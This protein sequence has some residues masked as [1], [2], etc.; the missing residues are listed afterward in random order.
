M[1]AFVFLPVI[2]WNSL[3][4][5]LVPLTNTVL[6]LGATMLL[7]WRWVKISI[8]FHLEAFL[9]ITFIILIVDRIYYYHYWYWYHILNFNSDCYYYYFII[10]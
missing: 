8:Y 3:C 10:N 5:V 6:L 9:L 7:T 4:F 2:S 1:L